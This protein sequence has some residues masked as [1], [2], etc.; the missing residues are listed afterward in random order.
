MVRPEDLITEEEQ[1]SSD[2]FALNVNSAKCAFD[3]NIYYYWNTRTK[4]TKVDV[5]NTPLLRELL[6]DPEVRIHVLAL[7]GEHWDISG[8]A[9]GDYILKPKGKLKS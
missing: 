4:S 1:E 2:K 7:Y 6:A 5:N 3:T 8:T 9:S